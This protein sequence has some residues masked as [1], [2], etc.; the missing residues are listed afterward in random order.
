MGQQGQLL[1]KARWQQALGGR[2]RGR[3]IRGTGSGWPARP[4]PRG[5]MARRGGGRQRRRQWEAAALS[6]C[7]LALGYGACAQPGFGTDSV[8]SSEA[9]TACRL[10]L[11]HR[12]LAL[13]AHAA[14]AAALVCKRLDVNRVCGYK[15]CRCRVQR[16]QAGRRGARR[17]GR[18]AILRVQWCV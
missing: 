14:A 2:R 9:A 8:Q 6:Q 10:R 3:C 17:G 15:E 1:E 4:E 5:R 18:A 7:C 16:R 12:K 13:A 11:T